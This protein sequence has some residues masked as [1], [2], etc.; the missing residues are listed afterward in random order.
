MEDEDENPFIEFH[1]QEMMHKDI[2]FIDI[3][4]ESTLEFN[5]EN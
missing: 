4:G 3:L 1:R 5:K 2:W